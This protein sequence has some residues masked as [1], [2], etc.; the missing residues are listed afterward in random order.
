MLFFLFAFPAD[1]FLFWVVGEGPLEVWLG[2]LDPCERHY[3]FVPRL[4]FIQDIFV[5]SN[6]L[7]FHNYAILLK[8][9][10]NLPYGLRP[11]VINRCDILQVPL[12]YIDLVLHR[13]DDLYHLF[14]KNLYI[15][16]DVSEVVVRV[17]VKQ[18]LLWLKLL[19]FSD[20]ALFYDLI[21]FALHRAGW[22]FSGWKTEVLVVWDGWWWKEGLRWL[23][24]NLGWFLFDCIFYKLLINFGQFICF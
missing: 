7:L 3:L 15:L 22:F 12:S 9:H 14:P 18:W 2:S 13:D 24:K 4:F 19:H 6:V 21:F 16:F 10:Q 8:L 5:L 11:H 23:S 17:V 20:E 1:D